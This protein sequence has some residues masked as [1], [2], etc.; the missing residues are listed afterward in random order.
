MFEKLLGIG[1]RIFGECT[2]LVET[3][4]RNEVRIRFEFNGGFIEQ[5]YSL[6]ALCQTDADFWKLFE[7]DFKSQ[8]M[9]IKKSGA[10]YS[11]NLK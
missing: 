9:A 11:L 4:R 10:N 6:L 5:W 1:Q 8:Y 3:N 7:D 2:L